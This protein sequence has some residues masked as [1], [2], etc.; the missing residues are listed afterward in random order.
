MQLDLA[1]VF[2]RDRLPLSVRDGKSL[3]ILC[4]PV[5]DRAWTSVVEFDGRNYVNGYLRLFA[6][7]DPSVTLDVAVMDPSVR[8]LR[9]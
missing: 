4:I 5:P 8:E 2:N 7:P 1:L 3:S 9:Q 6:I